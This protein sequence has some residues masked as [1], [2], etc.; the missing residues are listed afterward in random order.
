VGGVRFISDPDH[1]DSRAFKE[2]VLG[3]AFHVR[4]ISDPDH[5]NNKAND[6][7]QLDGLCP[8]EEGLKTRFP[9]VSFKR[10]DL[11]HSLQ[12]LLHADFCK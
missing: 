2:P 11:K 8:F 4:S 3:C 12:R 6:K 10:L 9:M 5:N 1:N 7:L